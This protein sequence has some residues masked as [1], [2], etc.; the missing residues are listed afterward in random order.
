MSEH[1]FNDAL[2]TIA[3]MVRRKEGN[4]LF[5]D[6]LNTFYLWL[7]G[8]RHMVKD[9]SARQETRC[10]H[11]GYVFWLA[12]RV[13]LYASSHRQNNTYYGFVT[14]HVEHWLEQD[15]LMV[16][17]IGYMSSSYEKSITHSLMGI[18]YKQYIFT[19]DVFQTLLPFL[20]SACTLHLK[21]KYFTIDFL[22]ICFY[23]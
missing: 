5:N 10:S 8:V 18:G 20:F 3:L 1:K 21:N 14:P 6:A 4:V 22:N 9:Q 19:C 13:L 17:D 2:N 11:M 23:L 12:A 7:C 15:I 16:R